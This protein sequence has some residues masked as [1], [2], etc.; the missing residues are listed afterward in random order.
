[1]NGLRIN[2][3]K[4][5]TYLGYCSRQAFSFKNK[6]RV[7]GS[8]FMV[9]VS[10]FRANPS[11]SQKAQSSVLSPRYFFLFLIPLLFALCVLPLH[12]AHAA[13][14]IELEWDPNTEPE[15]AGYKIHWG[16]SSGN[17]TA[18]K[19]VGKTTTCTLTG[20]DEGKTYY[21]AATAYDASSNESG[22]SNQISYT[23]PYS[24]TDGDGVPDY[25]DAFPSDPAETIDTDGDGIGNNA[26]ADDDGDKMP[27]IW[28]NQYGL[29]PLSDDAEEDADLDGISN[30]DEFLAGTDPIVPK[31]NSAPDSPVSISP[32]DEKRVTLTPI[33]QTDDFYDPDF[34][35]FH[36]E[37]QWQVTRQADNV[38]VL[39][40]TSPNSLN[41][42]QVP[43]A[44]L[45]QNTRYVWKAKFIDGH[46]AASDWSQPVTF[47]AG[48][49]PEDLDGNGIPDDQET[50]ATSD[51]NED[52]IL[53]VDQETIKCVNTKGKKSQVGISFEGSDT[54]LA[55][56]YLA[57]EDPGSLDS[58]FGKPNNLPFGLIDFRLRVVKPGDQAV[59]TVYFSDRAPKE[60]KWFK[61]DP[62]EGVW[63]DY[64][65]YAAMGA[66]K[67]SI[68]LRLQD[69]GQ[70]DADGI[71]NG[72]IVDP[73]GVAVS[74]SSIGSVSGESA[75][76]SGS[77]FIATVSSP[78]GITEKQVSSVWNVIH[79]RELAFGLVLL[80]LL[81]GI[82]IVMRRTKQRWE[83]FQRCYEMYH[84]RGTRFTANG[85]ISP[86]NA[87]KIK[88]PL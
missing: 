52:G 49:D 66:N 86:K 87:K 84:E 35:D 9:C 43:K 83:N 69:G 85:L 62:I 67:K 6:F 45:K 80:A 4:I 61:Y 29:D 77:C 34:G 76:G 28:E 17:Y 15:L 60:A 11:S 18:S 13:A 38:C 23:V 53:D 64:S 8:R 82:A 26:D 79:G 58:S 1:V 65:A 78:D 24:D 41:S 30:L 36:S 59:V 31:G 2:T 16:T 72:I 44:I 33:L 42:L 27:D 71:A 74:S 81:K 88:N 40:V 5:L 70:G 32:S 57:Y 50:D 68:T 54:V 75:D 19:D 63:V 20:L 3:N 7:Q 14:S 51:M 37:T 73:S 48:D 39:D 46:G 47:V 56:E 12:T 25:Q 10:E 22:Y 21:F 55:I